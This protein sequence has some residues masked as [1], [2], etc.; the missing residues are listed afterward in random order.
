MSV[1]IRCGFPI[2]C[3]LQPFPK[4]STVSIDPEAIISPF[5]NIANAVHINH[6]RDD[7][8]DDL[9][10]ENAELDDEVLDAES[11]HILKQLTTSNASDSDDSHFSG[12]VV[13]HAHAARGGTNPQAHK[14]SSKKP[15]PAPWSD[16]VG[17]IPNLRG[18][19]EEF[20][21]GYALL[22]LFNVICTMRVPRDTHTAG[23]SSTN[24]RMEERIVAWDVS[25]FV[26]Q[27]L[28]Y[29]HQFGII[30]ANGWT[31]TQWTTSFHIPA[32]FFLAG[33]C[34]SNLTY[35][36][37]CRLICYCVVGNFLNIYLET[38]LVYS[39]TWHW[40]S[41]GSISASSLWFLW[42]LLGCRILVA[43]IFAM[44][45]T[46]SS[47]SKIVSKLLPWMTVYIASHFL[48]HGTS[49]WHPG[50]PRID[51]C[52]HHFC[53]YAPYFATGLLF[54]P[55]C[56]AKIFQNR[57]IKC[58]S[59]IYIVL[60]FG[61]AALPQMRDWNQVYCLATTGQCLNGHFPD[62]TYTPYITFS[63]LL[64]DTEMCFLRL[65][66]VLSVISV[67]STFTSLLLEVAPE[68]TRCISSLGARTIYPYSLQATMLR[69]TCEVGFC[70]AVY[71][72]SKT[73]SMWLQYISTI[74]LAVMFVTVS[75]GKGT[76]V[77]IGWIVQP[78]W[79]KSSLEY[80]ASHLLR[81]TGFQ[82]ENRKSQP[83]A[84]KNSECG[85]HVISDV[86]QPGQDT[87][88][89]KLPFT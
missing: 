79:L 71:S 46:C 82:A 33:T 17:N 27:V 66:L 1:L 75:C 16:K 72:S 63:G 54:T 44:A 76:E 64:F 40:D 47:E 38:I 77:L 52:W 20:L 9:D 5:A 31:M 51:L 24:M 73:M 39:I 50:S 32:Y 48:A 4:R 56:W 55:Y 60:W 78:F 80:M 84:D 43:P 83:P 37:C 29:A 19:M 61:L 14:T 28:V 53:F 65:G 45:R 30:F 57:R 25:K 81:H 3:A 59:I 41:V 13:S 18:R 62:H 69:V 6:T 86:I 49:S 23:A 70:R 74:A 7:D 89:S 12:K 88:I 85:D 42:V 35:D 68:V 21:L 36:S 22:A 26:L 10:A 2:S 11:N 8:D 58:I 15:P 34:G 87:K 67:I